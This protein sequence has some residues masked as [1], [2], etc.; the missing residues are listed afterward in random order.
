MSEKIETKQ[1]ETFE[2]LGIA[3]LPDEALDSIAGGIQTVT[4]TYICDACGAVMASKDD[5]V[6]HASSTNHS[7]YHVSYTM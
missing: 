5:M 4:V 6:N 3:E 7:R 1:G 2:D